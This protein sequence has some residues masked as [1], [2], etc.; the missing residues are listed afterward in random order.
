MELMKQ[1][2]VGREM[3]EKKRRELQAL[4]YI[5]CLFVDPGAQHG[6]TAAA[7]EGRWPWGNGR[8]MQLFLWPVSEWWGKTPDRSK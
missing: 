3:E 4:P 7:T 2:F 1:F 5:L 8:G 6:G